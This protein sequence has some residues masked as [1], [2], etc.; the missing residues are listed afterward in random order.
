M[1]KDFWANATSRTG[2]MRPARMIIITKMFWAS[3]GSPSHPPT[4]S[5]AKTGIRSGMVVVPHII[6][7]PRS[8]D[9]RSG[10]LGGGREGGIGCNML[11]WCLHVSLLLS[12]VGGGREEWGAYGLSTRIKKASMREGTS[13][14]PQTS[15]PSPPQPPVLLNLFF[16]LQNHMF[17]FDSFR[18]PDA[19]NP[20]LAA[21]DVNAQQLEKQ[22]PAN[23][24]QRMASAE[25]LLHVSSSSSG[26]S[27]KRPSFSKLH[28]SFS[29]SSG[30]SSTQ[31]PSSLS[32]PFPANS[33][34]ML[35]LSRLRAADDGEFDDVLDL[36]LGEKDDDRNSFFLCHL[37]PTSSLSLGCPSFTCFTAFAP[38]SYNRSRVYPRPRHCLSKQ[39]RSIP[40]D[41]FKRYPRYFSE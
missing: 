12:I 29:S 34:G 35:A 4:L 10:D 14:N 19:T 26:P 24:L 32:I 2:R 22:R 39:S 9:G 28:N 31:S 3:D 17:R 7:H 25:A 11:D 33:W 40:S 36:L 18:K 27:I 5:R 13:T 41:F 30:S 23:F 1:R 8:I 6:P 37:L 20:S 38:F 21:S 15:T 16:L